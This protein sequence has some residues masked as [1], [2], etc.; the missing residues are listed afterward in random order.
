MPPPQWLMNWEDN[1]PRLLAECFAEFL[2]V[3]AYVRP[4]CSS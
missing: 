1:R 3:F 2:G 4:F